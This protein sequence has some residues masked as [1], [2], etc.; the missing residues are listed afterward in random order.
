MPMTLQVLYPTGDGTTFDHDYYATKHMALVAEHLGAHLQSAM[1]TKG[2]AGG[3]DAPPGFHAV[4]T[5]V[6]ENQAALD[7]AMAVSAPVMADLPNFTNS[8]ATILIG[9]QY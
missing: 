5:M 3:P 1:A 7:A 8:R 4:A 6:F 2:V 9:E